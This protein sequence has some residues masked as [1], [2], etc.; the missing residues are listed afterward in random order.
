MKE[1]SEAQDFCR[2]TFTRE[3]PAEM[4][5]EIVA[6]MARTRRMARFANATRTVAVVGALILFGMVALHRPVRQPAS[7]A[8]ARP[9]QSPGLASWKVR[10]IQFT[11]IART[12]PLDE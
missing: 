7:V 2:D 11:G 1:F 8:A 9:S 3:L 6:R 5:E 10:T 12:V 4:R